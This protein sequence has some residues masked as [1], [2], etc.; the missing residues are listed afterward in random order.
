MEFCLMK[1]A[2][3]DAF[4]TVFWQNCETLKTVKCFIR[5]QSTKKEYKVKKYFKNV[6]IKPRV[7]KIMF[8]NNTHSIFYFSSNI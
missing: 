6:N 8:L 3:R 2:S 4:I 1:T 5:K 7:R